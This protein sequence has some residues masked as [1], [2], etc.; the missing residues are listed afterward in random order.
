MK[1]IDRR[2]LENDLLRDFPSLKKDR[3]EH[4]NCLSYRDK[5]Y[6]YS[7]FIEFIPKGRY[8]RCFYFNTG[9]ELVDMWLENYFKNIDLDDNYEIHS[10][11]RN[12]S[13]VC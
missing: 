6:G 5:D 8:L 11:L 3:L 12:Q 9:N 4:K 10:S 1:R 7:V 2:K 13:W